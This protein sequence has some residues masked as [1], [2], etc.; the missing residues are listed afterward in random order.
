VFTQDADAAVRTKLVETGH[1]ENH[2]V[3]APGG[4]PAFLHTRL[5]GDEN[6][7]GEFEEL[8]DHRRTAV[9]RMNLDGARPTLLTDRDAGGRFAD[10]GFLDTTPEASPDGAFILWTSDRGNPALGARLWVMEA[11]GANP[12]QVAFADGAPTD[13]LEQDADPFWGAGDVI[14]FKRER[15]IGGTFSRVMVAAL[16]RGTMTLSGV[17]VRTDGAPGEFETNAPGDFDPKISPNGLWL[18]SYRHLDD[19]FVYRYMGLDI[20][21][22][23]W[24]AWVGLLSDPEEPGEASITRLAPD[25][26]VSDVFPRWNRAGDRLAM[27]SVDMDAFDAGQDPQDIVVMDLALSPGPPASVQVAARANVT[28]AFPGGWREGMPSWGTSPADAN[29]LVYS[30]LIDPY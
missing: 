9:A 2:V 6:G 13:G 16:D 30:A 1:A 12:R 8:F 5:V 11:G 10:D 17:T 3:F 27:W 18:A 21:F 4:A 23:D 22:G 28:H 25:P 19:A 7:D 14:A 26:R 24:D 20:P 29:R 15:F